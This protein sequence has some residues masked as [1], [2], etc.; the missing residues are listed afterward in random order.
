MRQRRVQKDRQCPF[1]RANES[2]VDP[3]GDKC[4]SEGDVRLAR[5]HRPSAW[6]TTLTGGLASTVEEPVEVGKEVDGNSHLPVFQIQSSL[7]Q[8]NGVEAT[9]AF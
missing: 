9:C 2:A 4:L 3:W 5:C 8:R 6:H 1:I 7:L